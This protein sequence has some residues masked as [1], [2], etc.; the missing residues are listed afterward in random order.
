ME[1]PIDPE[2]EKIVKNYI[3]KKH[4][5]PEHDYVIKPKN[6]TDDSGNIIVHVIHKH[7]RKNRGIA[8]GGKS[9]E[10]YINLEKK[11][12]VLELGFQ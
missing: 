6:I 2:I 1:R 9:I 12:V 11:T 10:L 3:S 7:D 4:N 8:G 5:W